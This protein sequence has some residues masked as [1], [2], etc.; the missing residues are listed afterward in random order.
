MIILHRRLQLHHSNCGVIN[1]A[2]KDGDSRMTTAHYDVRYDV[3]MIYSPCMTKHECDFVSIGFCDRS[4]CW[5]DV[6]Y[7]SRGII[8][9]NFGIDN[10]RADQIF[11]SFLITPVMFTK[12]NLQ[13]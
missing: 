7:D 8:P 9:A 12:F 2:V 3:Q 13:V 10:P 11:S 5:N 6:L 4:H 1:A